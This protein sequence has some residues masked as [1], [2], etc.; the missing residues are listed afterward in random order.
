MDDLQV[1]AVTITGLG[2]L[3]SSLAVCFKFGEWKGSVDKDR[4]N[5]QQFMIELREKIDDIFER[6]PP[7]RLL[8]EIATDAIYLRI[9]P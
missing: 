4:Q 6:L 1:L 5:F 9:S 8:E 7:R 2:L 3:I